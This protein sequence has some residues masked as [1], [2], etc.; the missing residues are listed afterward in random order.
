MGLNTVFLP[1]HLLKDTD[2]IFGPEFP[3]KFPS[4]GLLAIFYA[5]EI[6]KPK[7]LYIIGLDFYQG[8]YLVRREWNTPIEIMRNKMENTS[9]P[10]NVNRWIEQYQNVNF[11][12][13]TYF[14]G[15][16]P[17]RNLKLL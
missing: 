16:K 1:K 2:N 9:S 6:I 5:L 17:Q 4:T 3:N 14:D 10:E 8:D 12:I 15:F 11:I 13:S 7:N